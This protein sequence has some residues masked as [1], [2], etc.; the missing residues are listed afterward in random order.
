MAKIIIF[1]VSD[2]AELALFYLKHDSEHEPVAFTVDREF[3]IQDSFNGLPVVAFDEVENL[4]PPANYKFFAPLSGRNMNRNRE[5][6]YNKAKTKGYDLITYISSKAT[7]WPGVKIGKNCFVFE[8]N[9]LQP[10]STI[11]NNVILW[12]GNHIGHHGQIK[13]HVFFTSHVVLSGHC[14]VEPYC[15]FGVNSTIRDGLTIGRRYVCG[16]GS[17]CDEK[18]GCLECVYR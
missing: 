12:S 2:L 5:R 11:G 3:L 7:V 9:T 18:Y 4:Y 10:F 14:I 17:K 13:S 16:Y 1:G 6:I 8:D 15:Y